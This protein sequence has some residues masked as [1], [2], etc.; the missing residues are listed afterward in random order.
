MLVPHM[1]PVPKSFA[2]ACNF[3][4]S[5]QG[6]R[7]VVGNR[8]WDVKLL[9]YPNSTFCALSKGW[10]AFWKDNCLSPGYVCRFQMIH[11][12]TNQLQVFI[13]RASK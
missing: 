7:L 12:R 1:Q 6:V 9:S 2:R 5:G 4:R 3:R 13:E 8:W 11:K 10:V